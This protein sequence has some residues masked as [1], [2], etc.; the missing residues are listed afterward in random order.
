MNKDSQLLTEAY[1][2]T[3]YIL[4]ESEIQIVLNESVMDTIKR[5]GGKALIGLTAAAMTVGSGIKNAAAAAS[6]TTQA[7][8]N[9]IKDVIGS[10]KAHQYL[11][12]VSNKAMEL[13][14]AGDY[15]GLHSYA[16][17]LATKLGMSTA[18]LN[19]ALQ[20]FVANNHDTLLGGLRFLIQ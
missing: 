1:L 5:L 11:V 10:E 8:M 13:A 16:A 14:Q 3:R 7:A 20:S 2:K 15:N 9:G 4:T 18:E 19:A 6:D 17:S 12:D